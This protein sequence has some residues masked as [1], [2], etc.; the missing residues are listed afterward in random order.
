MAPHPRQGRAAAAHLQDA[1]VL[2]LARRPLQPAPQL[3]VRPRRGRAP[4]APHHQGHAVRHFPGACRAP[5]GPV[6][7]RSTQRGPA[8]PALVC[9]AVLRPPTCP[10]ACPPAT[11]LLQET[12][13]CL[14]TCPF[15]HSPDQLQLPL[16]DVRDK[17]MWALGGPPPSAPRLSAATLSAA[18]AAAG[19]SGS[20][21]KGG[22]AAGSSGSARGEW[23]YTAGPAPAVGAKAASV[24]SSS[25]ASG[26]PAAAASASSG[27][28]P[29]AGGAL[30]DTG[31]SLPPPA[32]TP[33]RSAAS[34]V[35]APKQQ[36]G[37]HA[38]H[39]AL[40]A[41][42]LGARQRPFAIRPCK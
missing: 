10:P 16:A 12:G 13:Q 40:L 17:L 8:R 9:C 2:Q 7:D 18:D 35:D 6:L 41:A 29:H 42:V 37:K 34:A 3:L 11:P 23:G 38:K 4:A 26:A 39:D 19:S 5:G 21:D 22:A 24:S 27:L 30:S 28:T 31:S 36:R 33:E 32:S 14:P 25:R 20:A 1:S 15:A